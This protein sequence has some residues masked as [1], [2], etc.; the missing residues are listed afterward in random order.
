M[1]FILFLSI[2]F[3]I[4]LTIFLIVYWKLVRHEKL[5]YDILRRQGVPGEP[6]VPLIGQL[7]T[8]NRAR[9]NDEYMMY[10]QKL[11]EK[12]GPVFLMGFGPLTRLIVHEPDLLAD[13]LGRSH[14]QD[15]KK[16]TFTSTVFKSI[17]GMHNLLVN[18]GEEHDRARKMLNPGFHFINLQSMVSI[19]INQTRKMIEELFISH[20]HPSVDLQKEF[21]ALTLAIIASCALGKNF[22]TVSNAKDVINQTFTVVLEAIEY[23]TMCMI[24]QI[25]FLAEM[26][27]W[28]KR[29]IDKGAQ[30]ITR[31]VEQIIT[32]RK[33]GRSES[34]CSERDI[35]DLLLSTVDD[36][37]QS[38][39]DEEIREQA[40]A[41]ILAGHET[42]A[43]LL[44][45]AMYVLMTNE[46]VLRACVDEIDQILPDDVDFTYEH[47]NS[48]PICEAVLLETLRLYPPAPFFARNCIHEH[49][50]GSEGGLQ[51][52]IPV[53]TT[54]FVNTY[55]LHRRP[56]FWPRPLEFDYSRWLRN[57]I[58]GYKPK[59]AHP[60]CYLPFA[61]GPRDCIGKNFALLEG[62]VILIML[63]KQCHFELESGQKIIPE[64]RIALRPKYG[65]WARVSK[66]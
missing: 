57:P 10:Y 14:A 40:L 8:I 21:S 61:A 41:F 51:L 48:L 47:I 36:L 30:E 24:N 29:I 5:C 1:S 53:N 26:P 34:L 25:P 17:I 64:M 12:H 50:I 37:G 4:I 38:F 46:T 6:F 11:A 13:V 2:F 49:T 65:L 23:R 63:L 54:I 44:S 16:T 55:V 7:F 19:M 59:L 9:A 56:E 28:H 62:K 45:W 66:R 3:C 22:E 32:D 31:F 43:N 60:F 27:F 35:L 15:Y 18:E 20:N 33:Q 52:K 42:T 58:T 39:T